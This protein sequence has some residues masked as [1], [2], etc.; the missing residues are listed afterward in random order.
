MASHTTQAEGPRRSSRLRPPAPELPPDAG[1]DAHVDPGAAA[2][3]QAGPESFT[4]EGVRPWR[5]AE[6]LSTLR[7]QIDAA[8]PGRSKKSDGTIG[9]ARHQDTGSD[10]NPHIVDGTVGVVTAFDITHDPAHGCDA[11]QIAARLHA[12]RDPRIKYIIWNRRIANSLPIGGAPAWAWR[13]YTGRNPHDK[14][15][16]VSVKAA[17]NFYDDASSWPLPPAGPG[18]TEALAIG[19][20]SQEEAALADIDLALAALAGANGKPLLQALIEARDMIDVLLARLAEETSLRQP[21]DGSESAR[22]GL[23]QLGPEYTRL[24][25]SCQ[26]NPARRGEVAW[27]CGRLSAYRAQYDKVAAASGVPWWFVGIVHALEASFSFTTHLHNGDPLTA[28]TVQVPKG[29]PPRWNPPNDWM[30]SA[31]DAMRFHGFG[32]TDD[33][34]LAATLYRFEAYN[35][36]G[37]RGRNLHSPYLWSFSNHYAAGKFVRD[38]RF[39][40]SAVSKQCGAAVMLKA[41]IETGHVVLGA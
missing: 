5:V 10:H 27:H 9:D 21:P 8:Y 18:A 34:G 22:P 33:W 36:F 29:R 14:H 15:C 31:V 20:E 1:V 7:A 17:S 32:G 16:H 38:G 24:F 28:R 12:A 11:G 41:M 13:A 35:G 3:F 30:S 25:A 37:Y 26:V 2:D 4:L 19:A 6:S 40:P 23:A 39:D